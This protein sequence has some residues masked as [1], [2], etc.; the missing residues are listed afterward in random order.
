MTKGALEAEIA[1]VV[2][3]FHREQQGRGPQEVRA[4][5]V[6]EMVLVRCSGI[7]TL[8]E[9]KLS[10][11]DDGRKLIQSA[12]R[13]LRSINHEEIEE[14]IGKLCDCAVIRSYCDTS[15]EA[16]E[17]IEVYILERNLEKQFAG[18]G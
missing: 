5:V 7:W 2:T 12:R 17:Q 1:N 15:V 6:G 18:K 16:G 3:K 13:E 8:T 11:S 14:I 10:V 9:A 4:F